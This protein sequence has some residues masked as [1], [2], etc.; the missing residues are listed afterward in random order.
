MQQETHGTSA[1]IKQF[2]QGYGLVLD[3][4]SKLLPSFKATCDYARE[5]YSSDVAFTVAGI[6][7]W[8]HE[9]TIGVAAIGVTI[10]GIVKALLGSRAKK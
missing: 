4:V 9:P 10:L 1:K 5:H 6:S 8:M 7:A 3:R 2:K